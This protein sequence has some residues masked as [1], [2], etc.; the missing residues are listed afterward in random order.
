[1]ANLRDLRLRMRAIRQTL[2]VT[3]A[4]NLISTSKLRKG[5][6]VLEDTEPYFTRIQK[7]M[8]DILSSVSDLRSE[9]FRK[10]DPSKPCR[11]AIV[12]IS[13]DKGL[14]GG[15]NVNV[16]RQVNEL[17]EK[18]KDPVLI[19]I[20]N[21]GYRYFAHTPRVIMEN[22]SYRSQLPTVDN[23]GEISEFIVSQFL[24]G[25]FSEVYVVYTHMYSTIK[26]VPTI[27][28]ILPLNA[29]TIQEELS[30]MGNMQRVGLRFEFLPSEEKVFDALVPL[31]IKGILY[32]SMVE[33]YA[34]EQSARMAA[35]DE[36]SK[37][38]EDMLAALQISYNR[39]RQAGI[40][41][42]MSEIVGGSAA[43]S[44]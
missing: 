37:S 5:R 7:S 29:A 6:R 30:S 34:S 43:L 17:C 8:F 4:M 33:A 22:F 31:Y 12:A 41:Q 10:P 1:M 14:A 20:G 36:A 25:M 44:D 23:A 16:F 15:Y 2:Q 42:E 13:S 19:L 9:F 26:L 38:A 24:W 39:A 40:T 35:M 27:N 32:G 18:V 21:I 3:K 11:T 28:Q